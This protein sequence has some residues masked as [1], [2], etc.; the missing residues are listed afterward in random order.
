MSP[1]TP[2]RGDFS[3]PRTLVGDRRLEL[4][5]DGRLKSPLQG[6]LTDA[7]DPAMPPAA[8]P[9]RGDFSR[10]RTLVGER[11]LELRVDGRLKSPLQGALTDASDPAMLLAAFP[12]RGDFSRPRT[13][14]TGLPFIPVL[15]AAQA[16]SRMAT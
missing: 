7:S 16:V 4:R 3:R 9:R 6:A 2:R 11:R 14:I 15:R 12:R 1:A 10:P 13:A 5:A 8:F